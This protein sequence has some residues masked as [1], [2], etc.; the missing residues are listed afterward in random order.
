MIKKLLLIPI[1]VLLFELP[2]FGQAACNPDPQ[3]TNPSTQNGLYPDTLTD[4]GPAYVGT[5][6]SQLVT[7][8]IPPDTT[9]S[10]F[11]T[12][13]W[14]STVLTGVTGLPA[15][16]TYA[17][18]NANGFGNPSRCAWKGN[19]I[20]CAIITGTP[21]TM[22]TYPLQFA[23]NNY[24]GFLGNQPYTILNYKIVVNAANDVNENPT[25]QILQQN[26]PNPFGNL[27][28][29][30][31]TAEDNGMAQFKIYNLIG[32]VIQQYD[33]KI[34]KGINKLELDA[35]DFDSGIYFYSIAHG[36][37]SFT[38]KMIVNK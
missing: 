23:T 9:V 37:T 18:W 31:F 8:V 32:T 29:I 12:I 7:I 6:Y 24:I 22:G 27:S 13:P 10:P 19:S 25:I 17:C 1:A 15:G 28:E 16:L 2:S 14:D 34:K 11:G 38:R 4:F 36:S 20:G 35:K 3:Y 5:P 33:V 26:N 21:T 30:Q